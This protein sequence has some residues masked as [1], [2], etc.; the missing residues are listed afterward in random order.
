[1]LFLRK[2][3]VLYMLQLLISPSVLQLKRKNITQTILRDWFYFYER[4]E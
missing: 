2:L 3:I 1:M 4:V